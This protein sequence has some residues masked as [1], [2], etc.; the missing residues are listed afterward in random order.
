MRPI[1]TWYFAILVSLPCFQFPNGNSHER[2]RMKSLS[3]SLTSS[4]GEENTII[5]QKQ[6]PQFRRIT[7]PSRNYSKG[8][9]K[10]PSSW[11]NS[12]QIKWI[13]SINL[14]SV[15]KKWK[16]IIQ[17]FIK[18]NNI[19]KKKTSTGIGDDRWREKDQKD[20]NQNRVGLDCIYRYFYYMRFKK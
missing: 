16:L 14:N 1:I 8:S 3:R 7:I 2:E 17:K 20:V 13:K 18:V 15:R 11:V 9:E 19:E 10:N 4:I 5:E 12:I 6:F